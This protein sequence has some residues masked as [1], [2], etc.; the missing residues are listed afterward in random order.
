M[1]NANIRIIQC[2]ISWYKMLATRLL[3]ERGTFTQFNRFH[4]NERLILFLPILGRLIN[5]FGSASVAEFGEC[6]YF[7]HTIWPNMAVEDNDVEFVCAPK[8]RQYSYDIKAASQ[9]SYAQWQWKVSRKT[10]EL[11][12]L[13]ITQSMAVIWDLCW[14][15]EGRYR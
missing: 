4:L 5:G 14:M 15:R 3:T 8:S 11:A 6:H 13:T 1:Q 2:S 10:T 12:G 9:W 7:F